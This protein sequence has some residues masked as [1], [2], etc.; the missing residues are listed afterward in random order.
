MPGDDVDRLYRLIAGAAMVGVPDGWAY[1]RIEVILFDDYNLSKFFYK[2]ELGVEVQHWPGFESLDVVV[3]SFYEMRG[4]MARATAMV[5][6]SV[7]FDLK[8]NG[9]F[10]VDFSY[11]DPVD[12]FGLELV[13]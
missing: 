3:E 11:E 2:D 1:I 10:H 6:K 8:P 4:V 5:W 7:R 9:E 12:V 13:D